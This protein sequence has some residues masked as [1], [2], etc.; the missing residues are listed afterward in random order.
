[1]KTGASIR[2]RGVETRALL[3]S[4]TWMSMLKGPLVSALATNLLPL[5][6]YS[7]A[8]IYKV[9]EPY[10]RARLGTAAHFYAQGE[11]V[12]DQGV[13]EVVDLA[14]HV[15]GALGQLLTLSHPYTLLTLSI[16]YSLNPDLCALHRA[17][18]TFIPGPETILGVREGYETRALLRSWTWLSMLKGPLVSAP[19]DPAP[20]VEGDLPAEREF[21][22]PW[23]EAGPP[24]HH[25]DQVDSDQK[26]H[27]GF[28][29]EKG[30]GSARPPSPRPSSRATCLR[31]GR[32][33]ARCKA[34]W[35]RLDVRLPGNGLGV[36]GTG[37]SGS[38][39]GSRVPVIDEVSSMRS[40]GSS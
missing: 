10:I 32:C 3:R 39:L 26:G 1:M 5:V 27:R 13:V 16:P 37:F 9:Y 31:R 6:Y 40:S 25:D 15:E 29:T 28:P 38:G 12:S 18:R 19:S 14:E 24:N 21:K 7:Q 17:L 35:K 30:L 8:V 36:G 20:V 23:R 2:C 22:L 11:G 33:K 4:W 34:T